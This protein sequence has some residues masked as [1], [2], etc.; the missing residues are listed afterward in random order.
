MEGEQKKRREKSKLYQSNKKRKKRR[1]VEV[2][3]G[4][5]GLTIEDKKDQVVVKD[6][7]ET[8][9]M[10]GMIFK[11]DWIVSFCGYLFCKQLSYPIC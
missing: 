4:S 5:L 8:L 10:K 7:K 3:S 1:I 6:V 9:P 2:P 11:D